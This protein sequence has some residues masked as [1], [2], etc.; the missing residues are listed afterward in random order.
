MDFDQIQNFERIPHLPE[1]PVFDYT[2]IDNNNNNNRNDEIQQ[3]DTPVMSYYYTP[4]N[5]KEKKN[6]NLIE[7][8]NEEKTSPE[9][10]K[11]IINYKITNIVSTFS[12]GRNIDLL[13]LA[14]S[15]KNSDYNPKKMKAVFVSRKEPKTKA[16]IFP[17]GKITV[18]GAK[19][20]EE[21]KL[22]SRLLAKDIKKLGYDVKFKNFEI[23]NMA[24]TYD[25]KK[26]IKLTKLNV[27]LT[28]NELNSFY[29]SELFPG[30]T[31]HMIKP[32]VCLNIFHSGKINITG[33]KSRQ[34]I[35][36]ALEKISYF[37]DN[38]EK[39]YTNFINKKKN[40]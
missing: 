33:A 1:T 21:S 27:V 36:D 24:A 6:P 25:A 28:S 3:S 22:A 23:V 12:L 19:T 9:T 8:I 30:L 16:I 17:Q 29:D 15:L 7:E 18:G 26:E 13:K 4:A 32:K 20:E 38:Y 11:K 31:C 14:R 2:I 10:Y 35:T 40:L 5:N 37:L 34:D 39:D